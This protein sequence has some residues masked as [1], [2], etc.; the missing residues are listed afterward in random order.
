MSAVV[1]RLGRGLL[2]GG[3]IGDMR[4]FLRRGRLLRLGGIAEEEA[5]RF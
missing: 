1:G 3:M 5:S 2:G 4:E